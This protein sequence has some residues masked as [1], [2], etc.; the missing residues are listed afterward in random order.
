[1]QDIPHPSWRAFV[2]AFLQNW[3]RLLLLMAAGTLLGYL[4]APYLPLYHRAE[5][6]L[7]VVLDDPATP[8]PP[9]L[10]YIQTERVRDALEHPRILE[11]V[12][13]RL[14]EDVRLSFSSPQQ[15][16]RNLTVDWRITERWYLVAYARGENRART[17]V[18]TWAQVVEEHIPQWE[19]TAQT[20]Q[21]WRLMER[22][23]LWEQL[24]LGR[25]LA[26]ARR[27]QEFFAAWREEQA[28]LPG[29]EPLSPAER[30][31]VLFWAAFAQTLNGSDILGMAPPPGSPRRAYLQWVEVWVQPRLPQVIAWLEAA[32]EENTAQMLAYARQQQEALEK[33]AI[34]LWT[35]LDMAVEGPAQVYGM[36]APTAGSLL[37]LAGG[38]V[39]GLLY[40]LGRSTFPHGRR[41]P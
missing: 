28:A 12:W 23:A 9:E 25:Q 2:A 30:Q 4:A 26:G 38:L 11:A 17:L 22:L 21:Q 15:L 34:T 3:P 16:A 18:E 7:K 13:Q 37:G 31:V 27:A 32:Q 35:P 19:E 10:L 1:M 36:P 39:L 5:V 40:V 41:L 6:S 24:Q 33:T 29:N 20:Y 8:L 14:P